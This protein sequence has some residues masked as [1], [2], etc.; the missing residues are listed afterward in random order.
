[1]AEEQK[2]AAPARNFQLNLVQVSDLACRILHHTF[3]VQAKDK[4]KAALK[5]LKSGKGLNV[6]TL[7]LTLTDESSGIESKLD[8]PMK[9]K[10]DYSEFRG[11][12]NLPSF[13]A[14]IRA[15]VS[16][17]AQTL[18]AKGNL[19]I[20]TEEGSGSGGALIHLPG[21]TELDGRYNVM[22]MMVEPIMERE[23]KLGV[24]VKLMYVDPAQY[25]EL[26]ELQSSKGET[27]SS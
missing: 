15:T 3:I 22:L 7:T 16:V 26:N 1:M 9:I 6:G 13:V 14:S 12:F 2:A 17:I 8:L 21:I 25:P 24:A 19:N 18:A 10:L 20:L 27:Q 23:S 5:D 4:A 11:S